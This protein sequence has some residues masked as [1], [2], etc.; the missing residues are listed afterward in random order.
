MSWAVLKEWFKQNWV[1]IA[2]RKRK[3][4]LFKKCGR[5][6]ASGSKRKKYP[7]CVPAAK[8]KSDDRRAKAGAVARKQAGMQRCWW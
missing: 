5:K 3:M 6:T 7:K 1:D 2:N 4:V 8:S